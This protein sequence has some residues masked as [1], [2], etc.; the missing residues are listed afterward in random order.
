MSA[1]EALYHAGESLA[2][3]LRIAGVKWGG[4]SNLESFVHVCVLFDNAI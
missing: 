4:G 3:I 1:K 2:F